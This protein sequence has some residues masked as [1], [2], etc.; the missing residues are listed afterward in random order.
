MENTDKAFTGTFEYSAELSS[1]GTDLQEFDMPHETSFHLRPAFF[2]EA[3]QLLA[4]S[5]ELEAFAFR[6]HTGVCGL[7]LLK[8]SPSS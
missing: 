6:Y 5:D 4:Q 7:K 2:L 3:E 1:T 8:Q